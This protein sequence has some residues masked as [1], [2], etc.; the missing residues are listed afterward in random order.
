MDRRTAHHGLLQPEEIAF[1]RSSQ[2]FWRLAETH[3]LNPVLFAN[4][5][6]PSCYRTQSRS[7]RFVRTELTIFFYRPLHVNRELVAGCH[8]S[9]GMVDSF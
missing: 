7:R 6:G 3:P 4:L 5:A 2:E 1:A 9:A 8:G